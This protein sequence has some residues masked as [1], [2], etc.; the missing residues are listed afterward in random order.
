[1]SDRPRI[2]LKH[3]PGIVKVA[4]VEC[5]YNDDD[6]GDVV[7]YELFIEDNCICTLTESFGKQYIQFYVRALKINPTSVTKAF[8]WF[9]FETM[10]WNT[11]IHL[12]DEMKSFNSTYQ[13]LRSIKDFEMY[14]TGASFSN[15]HE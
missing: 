6:E 9:V 3:K 7:Q 15:Y 8:N 4:I 5:N 13:F 1:M 11:Q 2:Y 14:K 12:K 10:W